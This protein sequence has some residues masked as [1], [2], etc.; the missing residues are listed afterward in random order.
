V[1]AAGEISNWGRVL[2]LL[3]QAPYGLNDPQYGTDIGFYLFSLPA[4][5]ALKN[6]I[7]GR[8]KS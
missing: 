7:Q 8:E 1:V 2:A 4:Y 3:Y 5:V 6:S